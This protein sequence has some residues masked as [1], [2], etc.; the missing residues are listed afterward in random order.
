MPNFLVEKIKI[1]LDGFYK[2]KLKDLIFTF[3]KSFLHYEMDR[4][5]KKA[6]VKR[7]RV[8]DLI[9]K[10]VEISGLSKQDY[11]IQLLGK[12]KINITADYRVADTIAKE[13]F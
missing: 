12:H 1:Y 7:I 5:A 3:S 4:G 9:N 2:L 10:Q 13:V 8:H 6:N 11:F